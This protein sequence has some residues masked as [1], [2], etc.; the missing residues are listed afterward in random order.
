MPG[1][2]PGQTATQRTGGN[3]W[4]GQWLIKDGSGR[5]LHSFGGI[6]NSQSDANRFATRW[7]AQQGYSYGTEIEVVPE[8]R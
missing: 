5:V 6:G 3:E 4:T 2:E 7:L 8:M 1:Q